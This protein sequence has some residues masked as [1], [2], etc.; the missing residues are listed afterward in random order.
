MAALIRI[1]ILGTCVAAGLAAA[2]AVT[3]RVP[4]SPVAAIE[5]DPPPADHAE[6]DP[7]ERFAEPTPLRPPEQLSA[8]S[9]QFGRQTLDRPATAVVRR[10]ASDSSLWNGRSPRDFSTVVVPAQRSVVVDPLGTFRDALE[11]IQVKQARAEETLSR[12]EQELPPQIA[13]PPPAQLPL[14]VEERPL[15]PPA[16]RVEIADDN[17]LVIEFEDEDLRRVLGMLGQAGGM[18]ILASPSVVGSVTASLTG[19]TPE[20]ALDGILRATGFALRRDGNFVYVATAEELLAMAHADSKINTR[21]Y[22]PNYVSANELQQLLA[23][24]LSNT[25]GTITVST[26]ADVGVQT[27][28]VNAGGDSFAGEEVVIVRDYEEVLA[29]ID[30]IV[31]EIDIRPLQ[32][33]L[34]AT[35]LSV[36]LDDRTAMGVDFELLRHQDTI[37]ITSGTPLDSLVTANFREGLKIGFLDSS[38]F[39]FIEA[40]E[41]I[42][43]TT[44]VASP[45]VMCLNKQRAEILIGSELGYVSTTVTETAATQ[46]VEFLEV[47]THLRIRPFVSSDG[48]IRMEV[49]P[50]LSEGSVRVEQGFTLPDKEVTQVTTNIMCQ[51]G[52]TV[53]IGGLIREDLATNATQIPVLGN[54]PMVGSLFRQ[55]SEEIDRREIIVLLT[56]K[57]V[58]DSGMWAEGMAATEQLRNRRD[59]FADKMNPFGKRHH[60]ER[61]LRLAR[62]A[63]AASDANAALRYV[64]QSLHWDPL[65]QAAVNLRAE[66]LAVHPD[67]EVA[68]DD[69]LQPGLSPL[70][71]RNRDYSRWGYP[72]R[73]LEFPGSGSPPEGLDLQ[74][75]ELPFDLEGEDQPLHSSGT[76]EQASYLETPSVLRQPF[77]VDA[78][79]TDQN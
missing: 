26:P 20:A 74:P 23:P 39:A 75:V 51:S 55:R 15:L 42:G 52:A 53:V 71:Q 9:V 50:E 30:T 6:A 45:R 65:H 44:V 35:I 14:E 58:D 48:S 2:Y 1:W 66:I 37:R 61:Y 57:I 13:V 33:V 24:M 34:E 64:N 67:L 11:K 59:V 38:L 70:D 76:V 28:E 18:N 10:H 19:V 25:L 63:W 22:R 17:Y 7:S 41:T 69:H 60:G 72:W 77:G 32:V 16:S 3:L 49:H 68:V 43:D 54:L 12:I 5:S 31:A 47:G 36:R 27:D 8:T 21:L 4:P 46:T 78:Q 40:L 56:P 29:E 79:V 73:P 62:A